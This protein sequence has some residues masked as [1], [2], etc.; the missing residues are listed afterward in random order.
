MLTE[1][2]SFV[3]WPGSGCYV[4]MARHWTEGRSLPWLRWRR[5]GKTKQWV[6]KRKLY[7][8]TSA[9][10]EEKVEKQQWRQGGERILNDLKMWLYVFCQHRVVMPWFEESWVTLN[11]MNIKSK[12]MYVHCRF[13][14]YDASLVLNGEQISLKPPWFPPF[15]SPGNWKP[16]LGLQRLLISNREAE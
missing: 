4:T 5:K 1:P 11:T 9:K 8:E 16:Q 14:L 12:W 13:A 7:K 3:G 10:V 6:R 15:G 2:R